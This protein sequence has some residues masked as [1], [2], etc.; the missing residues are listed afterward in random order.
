ML[1]WLP[2]FLRKQRWNMA[3]SKGLSKIETQKGKELSDLRA[4][5]VIKHIIQASDVAHTMQHWWHIY[6]KWNERLFKEMFIAFRAGRM[7]MDP[8]TF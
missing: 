4:T 1:S 5:I 3:F 8:L 6:R 2:I 7:D